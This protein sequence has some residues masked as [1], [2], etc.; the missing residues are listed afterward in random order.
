MVALELLVKAL[1]EG[2]DLVKMELVVEVVAV[3]HKQVRL[4]QLP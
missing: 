1:M 4:A 2:L 3:Q